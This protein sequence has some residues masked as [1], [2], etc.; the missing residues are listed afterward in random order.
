MIWKLESGSPRN[1]ISN[2]T[3]VRKI[4]PYKNIY[5][6]FC[7][8]K[9]IEKISK[10]WIKIQ[11]IIKYFLFKQLLIHKYLNY[12]MTPDLVFY[13]KFYIITY[14]FIYFR[15]G[16]FNYL[17]CVTSVYVC[18]L[19][20]NFENSLGSWK[21]NISCWIRFPKNHWLRRCSLFHAS[22]IYE[23]PIMFFILGLR[24]HGY[25]FGGGRTM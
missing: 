20:L 2:M 4:R 19:K 8:N 24:K 16:I 12:T 17:F 15:Y 25:S 10:K 5:V 3:C 9:S 21:W 6:F 22:H 7:L 14:I 18:L 1:Q 23:K 11:L 13:I